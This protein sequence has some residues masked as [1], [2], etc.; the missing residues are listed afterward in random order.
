MM[1]KDS[2]DVD[3]QIHSLSD[4]VKDRC[5][6]N[7]DKLEH[8]N[9]KTTGSGG[10]VPDITAV[11]LET[12]KMTEDDDDETDQT[13]QTT[14][15]TT[16]HTQ[17][18]EPNVTTSSSSSSNV[19]PH[20]L[21]NSGLLS[22][23]NVDDLQFAM[24]RSTPNLKEAMN[25]FHSMADLR[26]SSTSLDVTSDSNNNNNSTNN[27]NTLVQSMFSLMK[28]TTVVESTTTTST[29]TSTST[30][31]THTSTLT[32]TTSTSNLAETML[33]PTMST[34][35]TVTPAIG[36]PSTMGTPVQLSQSQSYNH[37]SDHSYSSESPTLESIREETRDYNDTAGP[38]VGGVRP[39]RVGHLFDHFLV[40]GLPSTLNLTCTRDEE[41]QRHKPEILYSYPPDTPLPNDMIAQFCFPNGVISRSSMRSDSSSSLNSVAFCNLS[42]LL[43]PAHSFV[44]LLNTPSTLY[45]GVCITKE[46]ELCTLPTFIPAPEKTAKDTEE[47]DTTEQRRKSFRKTYDFIA[48]RVYCFLSRFPFFN[49][50]FQMLHSILERER[51]FML[52]SMTQAKDPSCNIATMDIINMYYQVN[53]ET[54]KDKIQF[55][56]PGQDYKTDFH[57][58]QGGEDRMIAD[59]SLFTMSESMSLEDIVNIFAW[60]MVE[61]SILVVSKELGNISAFIFSFIALLKPYVWQ[62]C[63]IPILPDSLLETLDAPFPFFIGINELPPEIL[64]T[65]KDYLIVDID[66][67]RV[68][69]PDNPVQLP[70]AKK[71]LETLT[72]HRKETF[73]LQNKI[74]YD[75]LKNRHVQNIIATFNEYHSWLSEQISSGV[76]A[77]I[78]TKG[79]T[80]NATNNGTIDAPSSIELVNKQSIHFLE[81]QFKQVAE[82]L[83][84]SYQKFFE[85]FFHTQ[86]FGVNAVRLMLSIQD[87]HKTNINQIEHLESLIQMEEK[88]KEVLIEYQKMASRGGDKSVNVDLSTLKQQLRDSEGVIN[89]LR[90]SKKKLE[91]EALVVSPNKNNG[92][93]TSFLGLSEIKK[94]KLEFGHRRSRSVSDQVEKNILKKSMRPPSSTTIFDMTG[95]S[96]LT[97]SQYSPRSF[98][99]L[100]T[101]VSEKDETDTNVVVGSPL[102]SDHSVDSGDEGSSPSTP[103]KHQQ[104]PQSQQ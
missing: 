104:Q 21:E 86:M 102:S 8:Q 32:S 3:A 17:T 75:H 5:T 80:A 57:C 11:D 6:V 4:Q 26:T 23:R 68:I 64:K 15:H 14:D 38:L 98:S 77:C 70:G 91:L 93:L 48:P 9:N 41:R 76:I 87:R 81:D 53:M 100:M 22:R 30:S 62:C 34:P 79:T 97:K 20:S 103:I 46:E 96:A 58:P 66:S 54:V 7:D 83:P 56:V 92:T 28:E 85:Q 90:E 84:E 36:T 37:Y 10:D 61:R 94:K 78:N 59:W 19:H 31:T 99:P 69:Y 65:K 13:D 72:N 33:T 27:N 43:N 44:F 55:K 82:C 47:A 12:T 25:G 50:H 89:E 16:T 95:R 73:K 74:P 45:Y 24:F 88:S 67:K 18:I 42:H 2:S 51:M 101:D 1:D 35:L 29:S 40:V 52:F 60:A 49:L 71:L 63:F 39:S